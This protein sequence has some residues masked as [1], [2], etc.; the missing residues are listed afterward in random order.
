MPWDVRL[1]VPEL[2]EETLAK[3]PNMI[4]RVGMIFNDPHI[5]M[6]RP[7]YTI[8]NKISYQDVDGTNCTSPKPLDLEGTNNVASRL[9]NS[10]YPCIGVAS[11]SCQ[12]NTH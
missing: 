8:D 11:L 5:Q 10:A 3:L 1:P 2:N 9:I 4:S 12:S 7:C 6:A